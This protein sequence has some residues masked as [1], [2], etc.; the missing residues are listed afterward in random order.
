MENFNK[1]NDKFEVRCTLCGGDSIPLL[2]EFGWD[3]ENQKW[4]HEIYTFP[5]TPKEGV[6]DDQYTGNCG[7]S[8]HKY[9]G[10]TEAE[11]VKV[12]SARHKELTTLFQTTMMPPRTRTSRGECMAIIETVIDPDS[13]LIQDIRHYVYEGEA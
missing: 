9:C 13:E 11:W 3:A 5:E 12:G 6:Q 10:N 8:D 2:G 1:M 4:W 7:G